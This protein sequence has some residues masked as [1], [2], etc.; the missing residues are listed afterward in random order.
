M[1]G[2]GSSGQVVGA[3]ASGAKK[4]PNSDPDDAV[5]SLDTIVLLI[6]FTA[7][8][9]CND[10]PPPSQPATLLVMM[11]LV[12]LTE[13]QRSGLVGKRAHFRS[14]DTLE[15]D[16]AA[17]AG[18]R[19]VT[20][21]EVGIDHQ[22]AT[23]AIAHRTEG[24]GA[25]RVWLPGTRGIRIRSAHDEQTAAVAGCGWIRSL[26]EQDRVVLNAGRPRRTQAE[27][28]QRRRRC[29]SSRTPS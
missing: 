17:G 6:R 20:H 24:M 9:S 16:A 4:A 3:L 2:R 7:N 22:V 1:G 10:T 11:L 18:F 14:V 15:A 25:I 8:E 23:D 28:L 29:S 21:D 26:V 13:Y 19:S 27:K 5:E 12:T